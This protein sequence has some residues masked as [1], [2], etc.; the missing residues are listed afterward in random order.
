MTGTVDPSTT[1]RMRPAPPRGMSTS[2]RP[3]AVMRCF[4]DSCVVPGTSA[5]ASTGSPAASSASR[6]T[7][8]STVLESYADDEPRSSATL[9]LLSAEHGGV[10]GDV[11]ARLVDHADD[12]ERHAH[13]PHLQAVGQRVAAHDLADRVGQRRD[14]A[15]ARRRS[16]AAGRG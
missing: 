6:I 8:T 3:R 16:R 7:S 10:D 15:H 13:L 12:A 5:I 2:T 9:P 14:V 1:L 4:T 11:R